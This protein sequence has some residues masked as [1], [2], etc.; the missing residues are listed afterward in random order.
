MSI[1]RITLGKKVAFSVCQKCSVTQKYVKNARLASR[2]P[3]G[4]LLG[5]GRNTPAQTRPQ[6]G[7][8]QDACVIVSIVDDDERYWI[9]EKLATEKHLSIK[10]QMNYIIRNCEISK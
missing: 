1:L 4:P 6:S 3:P 9:N 7:I 5:C 8:V 2:C 10:K